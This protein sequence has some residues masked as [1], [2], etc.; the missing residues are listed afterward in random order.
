MH[1]REKLRRDA[2]AI[3]NA[4]LKSADPHAAI[5][6]FVRRDGAV[7]EIA[8]QRY[9]LS[10]YRNIYV[11]GAGKASARMAQAVEALVED[12]IAGSAVIVKYGYNAPTKSVKILEAGHPLPDHAGL[13]AAAN[14]IG[15]AKGAD[16][17]DLIL[18]LLSGGGSALLSCPREGIS[19]Q[20]K[21]ETTDWLLKSGAR[22]EE[23]NAVRKHISQVKGGGLARSA[24]PAT[25]VSLIMSDVVNDTIETI[26]SGPTAPDPTTYGGSVTILE[27]YG[28]W[29]H[30]P[31]AV[32]ELLQRGVRG[33][34][35]ETPK[36]GEA[37]FFK[38]TNV[39]VGNNRLATR[40]A[41]RRARE[42]GYRSCILS[43]SIEGETRDAAVFHV[44]VA[45]EVLISGEPIGRPA[46]LVS[47]GETTV[48]VRGEG[49][50]GRNQEF[51]LAAALEIEGS[52]QIVVLSGGTD[53]TDGP[54]NAAGGIVD[55]TTIRRA[56]D[57][58]LDGRAHLEKNDSYPFLRSTD[59][60]LVT[61]PT[62][63]N[64]M[65][66]RLILVG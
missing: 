27:K 44:A 2:L 13:K 60:L 20:D 55:G 23:I 8:G 10:Q 39:V 57:K 40:G 34:V 1:L 18:C 31:A 46:C 42:L 38:V 4:G 16:K 36:E 61:G 32:R 63:T 50:G 19:L 47:G 6:R 64:V 37:T 9:D 25:V 29:Q 45:K 22:I 49:M 28:L 12:R 24:Y 11:L 43:S 30:I 7:L 3:F 33:E 15:L 21:Q 53:G 54:T 48:T 58:G 17:D 26:A 52:E 62:L 51:A 66:L 14:V 5:R 41:K 56:K 35:A 65:D 59:D